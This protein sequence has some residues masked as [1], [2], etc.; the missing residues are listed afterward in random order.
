MLFFFLVFCRVISTYIS[1]ESL[2]VTFANGHSFLMNLDSLQRLHARDAF[3][4][5]I[6]DCGEGQGNV[7]KP[8][9]PINGEQNVLPGY[10]L[11]VRDGQIVQ[12]TKDHLLTK[13]IS[14]HF[15]GYEV[16]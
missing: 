11:F 6:S 1:Q 12:I 8:N 2:T 9:Q 4:N 15:V 14:E 10:Q 5:M 7:L 16:K 13:S 3:K